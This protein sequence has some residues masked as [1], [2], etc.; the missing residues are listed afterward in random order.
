AVLTAP[1]AGALRVT[2]GFDGPPAA[3]P[4]GLP[5]KV[6]G[7]ERGWTL[8]AAGLTA[9]LDR[10]SLDLTVSRPD[11]SGRFTGSLAVDFLEWPGG[12]AS[13]PRLPFR[14]NQGEAVY[15]LG[16]RF[17][18][19]ARNGGRWD[20]RVYEEYK[21]QG[22]RTYLPVPFLVSQNGWGLWLEG[23]EPSVFDLSSPDRAGIEVQ[24]RPRAGLEVGFTVFATSEP[25]AATAALVRANGGLEVPPGWAFG[26]WMS[27]N[28]WNTQERATRELRRTLAEDVPATVLVLEAWSDESS[29]Y[30]FNDSVYTPSGGPPKL[31]DFRFSGRW[32]DPKAFVDECRANGVRVVLWQIPVQKV[33]EDG[34]GLSREPHDADQAEMIER[35]YAIRNA[36]GSLYRCLGWWFPGGL[37][38]DFTNPQARDWWLGKRDYLLTELGISGFKTDGGEHLFGADLRAFDGRRGQELLNAYP[39]LYV[40][41]YHERVTEKL[42]GDGLTFS[43]AGFT[44]AGRFP[45][46]WA[47][48][49]NSTWTAFRTNLQ[50]GLSA[51]V[52]G[53]SMWTFDLGGFSGDIPSPDLYLRSTAAA[54]FAPLMQY[55][56]EYNATHDNR[57]RTPWNVAERHRDPDVLAVYRR[58]AQLRMRLAP[59]IHAEAVALAAEG[60]P[61]MRAPALEFPQA[62]DFLMADPYSFLLGRDLLVCPVVEQN[63]SARTLRLPPGQWLD[64]WTGA[65][66]EGSREITVPAPR[67]FIP[68]FIRAGSPR[69]EAWRKAIAV[70]TIGYPEP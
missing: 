33:L 68:V 56:S 53:V 19:P 36:D 45:S 14:L 42:N 70:P 9:R 29:F 15:G 27:S 21:E 60:R 41:A 8:E 34:D 7:D 51:G 48:D 6:S 61:L 57:D 46:H 63:A 13:G 30:A 4:G 32:P 58:Y 1:E 47:G 12:E 20:V 54:C 43:R 10:A 49:E 64:A 62:H 67:D 66:L 65:A 23:E 25:Y 35:G 31:S 22:E 28:E 37:V 69:A 50:A 2:L 3:Q 18:G 52:S 55:H 59:L 5:L 11:W 40:G 24:A 38:I 17:T 26:P 39:N 16:E 44:G